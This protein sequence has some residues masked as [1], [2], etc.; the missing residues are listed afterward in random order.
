MVPD[1]LGRGRV[2][3]FF[4]PYFCSTHGEVNRI[5]TVAEHLTQLEG[6]Q[7]PEFKCEH[8]S[9][10]LEFDALEE[11]YFL[12]AEG[13]FKPKPSP[14]LFIYYGPLEGEIMLCGYRFWHPSAQS[15]RYT[16]Y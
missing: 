2:E 14:V 13:E 10:P 7:A 11:S 9:V 6:K 16:V 5:I 1:S 8:C 15:A 12:F 3:S 4:A